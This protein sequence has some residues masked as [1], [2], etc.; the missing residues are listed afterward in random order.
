MGVCHPQMVR[1]CCNCFSGIITIKSNE[2]NRD[3]D[4]A[5]S[6][7]PVLNLLIV[8]FFP[9]VKLNTGWISPVLSDPTLTVVSL[10]H[11]DAKTR[12]TLFL[13]TSFTESL[14]SEYALLC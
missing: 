3:G 12:F 7:L 2:R 10:F 5:I 8:R 11:H 9:S 6:G 4:C 1:A 14:K 13:A